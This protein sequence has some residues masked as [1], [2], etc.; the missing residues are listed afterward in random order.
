MQ[1]QGGG[2]QQ[3]HHWW[4]DGAYHC[5]VGGGGFGIVSCGWSAGAASG[6]AASVLLCVGSG[7]C[8]AAFLTVSSMVQ[9]DGKHYGWLV[10]LV[11]GRWGILSSSWVRKTVGSWVTVRK[12]LGGKVA[13]HAVSH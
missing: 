2:W 1:L 6:N 4:K 12:E 10:G 5:H 3:C 11:M 13:A 9:G 8:V 7:D